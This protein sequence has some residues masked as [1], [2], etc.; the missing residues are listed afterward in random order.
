MS[1]YVKKYDL[2]CVL[3][4]LW[5]WLLPIIFV[6]FTKKN[7]PFLPKCFNS[8]YKI[9]DLFATRQAFWS[10]YYFEVKFK[11]SEKWQ[12]VDE[13]CLSS[14]QPFGYHTRL[15]LALDR[16]L[17]DPRIN[18]ET[19]YSFFIRERLKAIFPQEEISQVKIITV[20]CISGGEIARPKQHWIKPPLIQVPLVQQQIMFTYTF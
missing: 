18:L 16:Y 5:F 17:A 3:F 7:V 15:D 11:G 4:F 14:M 8:F 19:A 10:N 20:R 13:R 2:F 9:A 12:E 1:R 6:G